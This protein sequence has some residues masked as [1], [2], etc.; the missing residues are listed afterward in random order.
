VDAADTQPAQPSRQDEGTQATRSNQ[1]DG[2]PRQ[3]QQ[4]QQQLRELQ[5]RDHEV[6]AHEQ[7]HRAAGA[8]LVRGGTSFTLVRGSDGRQYAVGGEV[9]IDTAAV[10]NDPDATLRKAQQI[11]RAALAPAEPSTQDRA[12][13]A[14]AASMEQ[15]ARSELIRA[16]LAAGQEQPD[17]STPEARP[18]S[19]AALARNNR[20]R[21]FDALRQTLPNGPPSVEIFA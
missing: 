18:T 5:A 7:A 11:R 19:I 4:E 3:Q 12:V 17:T 10:R 14:Q 6:R 16:R 20:E 13:A 15:Q 21:L 1:T 9:S 2:D 8:G